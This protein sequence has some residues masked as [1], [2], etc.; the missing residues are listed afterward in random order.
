LAVALASFTGVVAGCT[1]TVGEGD[2]DIEAAR[3]FDGYPLYWVGEH[4]E[5][6]DLEHLSARP[7][8]FTTFSYGT[9]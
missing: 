1:Q 5:Q 6:W 4:F 8:G 9:C 2:P 3:S 7:D